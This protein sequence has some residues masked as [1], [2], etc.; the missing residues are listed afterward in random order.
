MIC[1]RCK[2]K[3]TFFTESEITRCHHC[4]WDDEGC[5]GYLDLLKAC[6]DIAH[7]LAG[8]REMIAELDDYGV[9]EH[10]GKAMWAALNQM[11]RRKTQLRAAIEKATPAGA[12]GGDS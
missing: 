5:P 12:T 8:W 11:D 10:V 2:S 1:P 4:G 9:P 7:E 3:D 6:E